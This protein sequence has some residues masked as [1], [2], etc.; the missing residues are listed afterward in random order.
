M[1]QK[2]LLRSHLKK[3]TIMGKETQKV[4]GTPYPQIRKT[5]NHAQT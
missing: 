3:Q 4:K 2:T 1:Q 5:I